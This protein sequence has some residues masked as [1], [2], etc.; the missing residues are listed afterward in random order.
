MDSEDMKSELRH[1][2]A[3]ALLQSAPLCRLAYTGPDDLPRAIPI[4]FFW[5]GERVAL[6]TA[7]TAPKVRALKRRPD[8]ALTIDTGSESGT[9]KALLIRGPATLEVVEGVPDEFIAAA[10]KSL[11]D[12][13]RA[14]FEQQVRSVYDEMVRISIEPTWARFYD[15]GAGRV[16]GFLAELAG[17][18]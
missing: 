17:D 1:P 14:A 13:Q 15:F 6:Y 3:Q 16:P 5:T 2:G 9:A 11:D 10:G 7:T 4:G 8:V 18:G 12:E